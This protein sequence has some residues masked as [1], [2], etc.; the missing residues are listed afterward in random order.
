MTF[1][2]FYLSLY[3][4]LY[5]DLSSAKDFCKDE[6]V[7]GKTISYYFRGY[8]NI[9]KWVLLQKKSSN[10]SLL[11]IAAISDI[12]IILQHATR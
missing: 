5:N 9:E 12:L 1:K 2:L 6:N 4:M 11:Q 7:H 3:F 10:F 8:F